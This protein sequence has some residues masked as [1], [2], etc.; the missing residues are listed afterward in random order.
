MPLVDALVK[1]KARDQRLL[2]R[3]ERLDTA[4]YAQYEVVQEV[5]GKGILL[6]DDVVTTGA[7][8]NKAAA[9]LKQAGAARVDVLALAR[10]Y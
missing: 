2:S 1:H 8:M 5:A 6:L 10:V 3:E 4:T 7:T 9:A